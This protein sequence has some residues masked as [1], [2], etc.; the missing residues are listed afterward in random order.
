MKSLA[1]LLCVCLLV[2]LASCSGG[3][4]VPTVRDYTTG[5]PPHNVNPQSVIAR[6]PPDQPYCTGGGGGGGGCACGLEPG[7]NTFDENDCIAL[8]GVYLS[9][10]QNPYYEGVVDCAYSGKPKVTQEN[11][12]GCQG[13]VT[14]TYD[15]YG[16]GTGTV[17]PLGMSGWQRTLYKGIRVSHDCSVTADGIADGYL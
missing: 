8:G 16:K 15:S 11:P 12:E 17:K 7:Y 6:C 10:W 13:D 14:V 1:K 3:G 9:L 4:S 2:A 5:T